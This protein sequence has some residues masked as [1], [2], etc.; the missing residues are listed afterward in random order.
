VVKPKTRT[1][2]DDGAPRGVLCDRTENKF[3]A[4]LR[5]GRA[6]EQV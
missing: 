5:P 6:L 2:T 3:R 1:E 4:L